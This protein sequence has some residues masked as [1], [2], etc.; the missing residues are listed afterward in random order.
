MRI[1]HLYEMLIRR[2][3]LRVI[4]EVERSADLAHK[5]S[6][7]CLKGLAYSLQGKLIEAELALQNVESDQ[8]D[9]LSKG[10]YFEAKMLIEASHHGEKESIEGMAK[11]AIEFNPRSIFARR[12]LG[13]L[14]ESRGNFMSAFGEYQAALEIVP[15]SQRT[16]LDCARVLMVLKR[17][18]ESFAYI[19]RAKGSFKR[20]LYRISAIMRSRWRIL[21]IIALALLLLNP[22]T[23]VYVFWV[24]IVASALGALYALLQRDGLILSTS[25]YFAIAALV[26]GAL[27]WLFET[28]TP[29]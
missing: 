22:V 19:R 25:A 24:L 11:K 28:V 4:D 20:E 5:S 14:E 29:T 6:G 16:L 27:K 17:Q 21:V 3:Y 23:S 13:R 12:I 1:E 15:T 2:D 9:E 8:L 10:I 7:H 26:F 18:Q